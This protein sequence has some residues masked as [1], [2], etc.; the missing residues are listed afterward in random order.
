[1]NIALV[2]LNQQWENKKQNILNCE[3]YIIEAIKRN[4]EL[5]IFPEMTLTG[6]SMNINKISEKYEDSDTIKIFKSFAIKYNIAIIFGLVIK[7]DDKGLN[8][9][10]FMDNK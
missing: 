5:I 6:F 8:T 2:S 3:N 4:S 1:M 9:L 10:I 7:N